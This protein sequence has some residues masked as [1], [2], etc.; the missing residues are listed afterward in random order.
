MQPGDV[1]GLGRIYLAFPILISVFLCELVKTR[2][3]A[4]LE[5]K[6]QS[7]YLIFL[8]FIFCGNFPPFCFPSFVILG[9]R[10][11]RASLK[12][13]AHAPQ[14]LQCSPSVELML[15]G[16]RGNFSLF[17]S[18]LFLQTLKWMF[19]LPRTSFSCLVHVPSEWRLSLQHFEVL[20]FWTS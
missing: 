5:V 8:F 7:W 6:G 11:V 20:F 19:V 16:G 14:I 2:Q 18:F 3:P 12:M 4:I 10:K 1:C 13:A 15:S 9:H 17:P